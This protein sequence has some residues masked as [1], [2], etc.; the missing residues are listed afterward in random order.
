MTSN[1]PLRVIPLPGMGAEDVLVGED[2]TV[3][4]ATED[5]SV[6]AVHR[7]GDLVTRVGR[8]RGRPLGLEW[9]PDGRLLLCDAHEGLLAMDLA[10]GGLESLLTHVDGVRMRC[11]NNAAVAEDGTIYFSD[12]TTR[13]PLEEWRADLA[14]DTRTGRLIRRSPT[15]E[16]EVLLDGLR[17]ANGVAL[18][19]DESFVCVAESTGRSVVRHWLSGERAGST[20][21]L[22]TELPG[23]PDNIALGTDGLVWVSL[24][25]PRLAV[26]EA[27]LRMPFPVRRLVGRI[28][29]TL[30]PKPKRSVWVRALDDQG[31]VVHDHSLDSDDF[32]MVTG[33]R[34]HHGRVWLG[35]LME[36]AVACFDI[37]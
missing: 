7:D 12:S 31:A 6:Y 9:L 29:T 8:T 18:A 23:Y 22:A 20:D 26:L 25:S 11:P 21:H 30:Q 35:S 13:H 5:G 2:G 1:R 19:A 3:Y 14:E 10:T 28:P 34:E 17:F 32:H 27:V 33:V 4:T 15:G 24:G 37:D 16:V 36:S